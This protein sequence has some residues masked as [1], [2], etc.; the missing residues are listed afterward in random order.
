MNRLC[1]AGFA[2]LV[3]VC[4]GCGHG[5]ASTGDDEVWGGKRRVQPPPPPPARKQKLVRLLESSEHPSEEAVRKL[6]DGIDSDL[7]D[8]MSDGVADVSLRLKAVE[9]LGF[10]QNRRARLVLRSVLTDPSWEKP[11]RVVALSAIA[12]SVGVEAFDVIKPFILDPDPDIRVA[13]VK[14][15][16]I[17][18]TPEALEL[19][20]THQLRERDPGV[21]DAVDGAIRKLEF[22]RF[23]VQ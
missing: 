23:E 16:E 17:V 9:A 19:L 2:L 20:K 4:V 3:F 10:F 12:R 18:G 7:A 22:N 13:G 5:P 21:L 1:L 14:A 15:L 6:G 11:Y 8:I